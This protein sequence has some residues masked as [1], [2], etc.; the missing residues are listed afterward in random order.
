MGRRGDT[1]SA[2]A[3]LPQD[4][5]VKGEGGRWRGKEGEVKKGGRERSVGKLVWDGDGGREALLERKMDR[6][7]K[8]VSD[9]AAKEGRRHKK[10]GRKEE[11]KV[12]TQLHAADGS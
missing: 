12:K 9:V 10:E 8:G 5:E 2:D 1:G 3:T 11:V 7:M 4:K 6:V